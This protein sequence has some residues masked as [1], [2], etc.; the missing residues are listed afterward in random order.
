MKFDLPAIGAAPPRSSSRTGTLSP[1]VGLMLA[2]ALALA[3]AILGGFGAVGVWNARRAAS[4]FPFRSLATSWDHAIPTV[5]GWVWVY[6]TYFPSLLLPFAFRRFRR[7]QSVFLRVCAG[8]V[9]QLVVCLPLFAL[10]YR[11]WHRPTAAVGLSDW[12]L[13][14]I[15]RIDPG[16]NVFPSM[17]VSFVSYLACV[18][19]HLCGARVGA[20]LWGFCALIMASTLFTKQH[21]LVDLPTGLLVGVAIFALVFWS[22]YSP[23]Q[24]RTGPVSQ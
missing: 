7:E 4:G 9:L 17:H 1:S 23:F 2:S 18:G 6:V 14:T 11:I 5:S 16:F 20:A 10:P 15:H 13:A 3:T 12:M 19:T 8:Y 24:K 21:Y 22:G